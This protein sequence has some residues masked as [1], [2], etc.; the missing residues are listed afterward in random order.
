MPAA[1][2]AREIR[3]IGVLN[4]AIGEAVVAVRGFE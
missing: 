3:I 2:G 4:D 1:C